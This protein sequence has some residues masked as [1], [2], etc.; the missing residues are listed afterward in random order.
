MPAEAAPRA[1]WQNP[2]VRSMEAEI[3]AL[4]RENERL[5]TLLA[6]ARLPFPARWGLTPQQAAFLALL[7]GQAGCVPH[8]R[9]ALALAGGKGPLT[10]Q[11]LQVIACHARRKTA[12]AGIAIEAYRGAGYGLTPEGRAALGRA[13]ESIARLRRA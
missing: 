6:P 5:R 13:V 11:Q 2:V 4:R 1:W 7:A 9:L 3:A 10:R 8:Q 12:P